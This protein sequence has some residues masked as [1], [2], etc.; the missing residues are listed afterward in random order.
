MSGTLEPL[1]E[2]PKAKTGNAHDTGFV[3]ASVTCVPTVRI[4][5]MAVVGS[6]EDGI[7]GDCATPAVESALD[8]IIVAASAS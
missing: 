3:D 7:S 1:G 2:R 5:A 6:I 8:L 4:A